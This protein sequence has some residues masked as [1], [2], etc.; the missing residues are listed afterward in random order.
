MSASLP[1]ARS[2]EA[3]LVAASVFMAR[4][5]RRLGDSSPCPTGAGCPSFGGQRTGGASS[6]GRRSLWANSGSRRMRSRS[7]I[8]TSKGGPLIDGRVVSL[9]R[10]VLGASAWRCITLLSSEKQLGRLRQMQSRRGT[11]ADPASVHLVARANHPAKP[12][13]SS[14]THNPSIERT[15]TSRLRP[16]AAAAH[17]KR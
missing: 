16:L 2:P 15:S 3:L 11:G 10:R 1:F 6:T 4:G 13:A 7:S 8:S 9:G 14:V 12:G 17:V 5:S